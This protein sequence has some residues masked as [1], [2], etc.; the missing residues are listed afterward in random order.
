M[1]GDQFGFTYKSDADLHA[2]ISVAAERVKDC[3]EKY[4][5]DG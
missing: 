3:L 1:E 5:L 4:S 2:L